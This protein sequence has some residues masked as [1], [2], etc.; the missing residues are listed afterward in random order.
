MTSF[1][2]DLLITNGKIHDPVQGLNGEVKDIGMRNGKIVDIKNTPDFEADTTL[3]A[4]GCRIFAGG[5]D[6]H[7]HIA[8][9]SINRARRL[10]Q[11]DFHEAENEE[12]K[13]VRSSNPRIQN[14]ETGALIPTNALTGYRYAA[15]GYTTAVDAAVTPA[16]ARHTHLEFDNTPCIDKAGL[17]VLSDQ[18]LVFDALSRGDFKTAKHLSGE[19][20]FE[21][22]LYGIKAVNPGGSRHWKHARGLIKGLD[23]KLDHTDLTPRKLVRDLAKIAHELELPHPLHLHANRLGVPGNVET[24]LET[25]KALEGVPTHLAHAQFHIYDSSESKGGSSFKS[26]VE[27]FLNAFSQHPE[28]TLDIGQVYFG[29]AVT[30]T[31]DRPVEHLLW[32]LTGSTWVNLDTELET[33]CGILPLEYRNSSDAHAIQFATGLELLL[34]SPDPWRM[35]LSTDHPNG[36]SFVVYP[37]IIAC[38][39]DKNFREAEVKKIRAPGFKNTLLS[40]GIDREYSFDEIAIITRAAPAKILGLKHKGHLSPGADADITIYNDDPDRLRMFESPRYVIHQGMVL[41]DDGDLRMGSKGKTYC[42]SLES[43]SLAQNQLIEWRKKTSTV[44]HNQH[45]LLEYEKRH[46]TPVN[47]SDD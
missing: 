45:A 38:L 34:L 33:G 24:T 13:I 28:V 43:D 23:Q 9:P 42:T 27:K 41:V 8:G 30:L 22:G 39:M 46:L 17:L 20:L 12:G 1:M 7:S 6:I 10:F 15:M 47:K 32:Q 37:R 29:G 31:Q 4:T 2:N 36:A 5:I 19:L 44:H 25:L 18:R 16:G 3:D 26:G 21:N 14:T 11:A 35:V 40:A